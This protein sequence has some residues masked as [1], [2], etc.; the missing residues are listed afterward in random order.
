MPRGI[1][2]GRVTSGC[3]LATRTAT[4]RGLCSVANDWAGFCA[5][6][7]ERR[8]DD[9]LVGPVFWPY[10]NRIGGEP[11]II[12]TRPHSLRPNRLCADHPTSNL[13]CFLC[14]SHHASV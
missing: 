2:R 5:I 14:P 8:R 7:T 4:A 11:S 10:G 3:F 12:H 9:G 1:T 13:D 6:I